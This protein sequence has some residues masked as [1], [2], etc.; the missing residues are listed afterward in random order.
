MKNMKRWQKRLINPKFAIKN[1]KMS[2]VTIVNNQDQVIGVEEK[3]I[4]R[5][6][7]LISN[8]SD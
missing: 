6:K 5:E 2:K 1:K 8:P 4:A 3:S 7:E